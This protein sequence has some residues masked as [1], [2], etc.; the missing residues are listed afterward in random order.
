MTPHEFLISHGWRFV[1][2]KKGQHGQTSKFFDH[3]EHQH[4]WGMFTTSDGMKHQKD[5]MKHGT[6]DCIKP[7]ER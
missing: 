6:C 7:E 1:G 3:P 5:F 2:T 4:D